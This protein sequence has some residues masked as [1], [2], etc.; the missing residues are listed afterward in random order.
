[1]ADKQ[2]PSRSP[3]FSLISKAVDIVQE[4]EGGKMSWEKMQ[5]KISNAKAQGELVAK[6]YKEVKDDPRYPDESAVVEAL[7]SE[8]KNVEKVFG[9]REQFSEKMQ[10]KKGFWKSLREKVGKGAK[11]AVKGAILGGLAFLAYKYLWPQA[12]NRV[13]SYLHSYSTDAG[14]ENLNRDTKATAE[15]LG[16]EHQKAPAAATGVSPNRPRENE[17][18]PEMPGPVQLPPSPKKR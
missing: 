7:Q 1:M 10:E 9:D 12:R 16:R 6:L 14:R 3:E 8:L 15:N 11:L 2:T 17:S 18:Y 4:Q 5:A 13:M